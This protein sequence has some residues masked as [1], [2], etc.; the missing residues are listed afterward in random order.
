MPSFAHIASNYAEGPPKQVPGHAGLLRMTRLLLEE[1]VPAD[2][3]VL[4]LGAGGGMELSVFTDA[5]PSWTFDGVDPSAEMLE[6]ARLATLN[7][8]QRVHLHQGYIETAPEGPFDGATSILTMHFIPRDQRLATLREMRRRMKPGAPLVTA[9][10][11]FPQDEQ[12]REVW[13]KRHAAFAV[14]NGFNPAQAE[15]GRLAILARL[16]ILSPEEDEAL[17]REAGFEGISLFYAAFDFKGWVAY[18]T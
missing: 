12:S 1:C 18:A 13:S 6:T 4:V 7:H 14:S 5:Q 3:R 8:A 11:S 9:H 2:G 17:M 15:A 10:M 16:P